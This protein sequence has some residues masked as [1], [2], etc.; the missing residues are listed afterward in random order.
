MLVEVATAQVLFQEF[1]LVVEVV[2]LQQLEV[3]QVL[4]VVELE[5]Q[6]HQTI[7]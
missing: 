1:L 2:E 6:V 5:V 3:M 7:F 4:V